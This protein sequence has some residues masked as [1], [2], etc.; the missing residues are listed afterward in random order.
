MSPNFDDTKWYS[1]TSSTQST[2]TWA[3]LLRS[4]DEIPQEFQSAFPENQDPFPYTLLIPE[5][6][7]SL[8]RKRNK[9]I[10][11]LYNDQFVLLELQQNEIKTNTNKLSDVLC[12]ERGKKLLHSWLKIII[13]SGELSITFNT[14]NDYLF[15]PIIEKIRQ[16]MSGSSTDDISLVEYQNELSKFD[17]LHTVNFK[18]M[19][20]GKKSIRPN[21][22]IIYIAYQPERT[23]QEINLFNKSLLRRYIT[24]HLSILTKK[25]LIL[26][27]D[28]KPIKTDRDN[29]YGGVITHLPRCQIHDISFT[30]GP[31][32]SNCTMEIIL[33]GNTRITSE[34]SF[35][36][37]DLFL[38]QKYME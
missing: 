33:P 35:N 5:D 16:G 27:K 32:N 28:E 11:C 34:F 22:P 19:N 36:N 30:S 1:Y 8:F 26:I 38:L 37:K 25:E 7:L 29:K 20:Y 2:R 6:R 13:A 9:K 14:T 10:I 18:Y 4:Y 23:V 3:R 12:L 31:E 15:I 17:Y 21:D 24:D